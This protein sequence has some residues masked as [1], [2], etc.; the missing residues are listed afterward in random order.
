VPEWF[1]VAAER[2]LDDRGR[3]REHGALPG[4]VEG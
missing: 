3:Q 2:V 1:P 4:G